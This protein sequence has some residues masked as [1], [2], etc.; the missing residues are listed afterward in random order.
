MRSQLRDSANGVR[1]IITE[2]LAELNAKETDAPR[3]Q[4]ATIQVASG[5]PQRAATLHREECST[6]PPPSRNSRTK[7]IEEGTYLQSS[8]NTYCN[9]LVCVDAT[10]PSV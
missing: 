10:V 3:R 1:R 8:C 9:L 2:L 7:L 5:Q 4:R 6:L